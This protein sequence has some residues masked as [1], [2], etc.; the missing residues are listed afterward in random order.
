[1]D[2]LDVPLFGICPQV[3]GTK[4]QTELRKPLPQRRLA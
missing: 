2:V 1:M 3:G 4:E